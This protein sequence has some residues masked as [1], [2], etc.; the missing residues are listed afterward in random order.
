MLNECYHASFIFKYSIMYLPYILVIKQNSAI[1]VHT[2]SQLI[3]L[4]HSTTH[5]R[6]QELFSM[7]KSNNS[8]Y[9]HYNGGGGDV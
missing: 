2:H 1:V 7:V 9:F 6:S 4:Y 5:N 8:L 3:R